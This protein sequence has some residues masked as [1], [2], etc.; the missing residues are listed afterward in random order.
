[1]VDGNDYTLPYFTAH[2]LLPHDDDTKQVGEIFQDCHMAGMVLDVPSADIATMRFDAMG[3]C[4]TLVVW[5][6]DPGWGEPTFDDDDTFIVTACAGSVSI[7]VAGGTPSSL[8]EFDVRAARLTWMNNLL[9]PNRTRRIG[10][11]HPK[12]FPVMSRTVGLDLTIYIEDYDLYVQTFAG[13]QNPVDDHGWLCT[14]LDGDI[15]VIIESPAQI[16]ATGEYHQLRFLTDQGNCKLLTRPIVLA[17]NQP[18]IL[19]ARA[20]MTEVDSGRPFY[21][22]IQNSTA[23]YA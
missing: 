2:R 10:N 18:V 14:P 17:P 9:P 3:R 22:Y 21:F 7:S 8:T 15:D 19:A 16:G 13:P 23:S 1:M 20:T 12:D 11:P 5:D 6:K 4:N